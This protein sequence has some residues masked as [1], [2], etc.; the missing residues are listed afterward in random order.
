MWVEA[1]HEGGHYF[2]HSAHLHFDS[3]HLDTVPPPA[4]TTVQLEFTLP[5]DRQPTWV[6]GEVVADGDEPRGGMFV[7]FRDVEESTRERLHAFID[8]ARRRASCE[9]REMPLLASAAR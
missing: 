9:T 4:G 1:V 3:I 7:R 8:R 5:G 6:Q 2:H